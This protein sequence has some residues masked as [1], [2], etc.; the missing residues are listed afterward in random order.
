MA[1]TTT[2]YPAVRLQRTLPAPPERVYRAWLDPELL[3]CWLAPSSWEVT[4]VEVDEVVGGHY[5]I[6]QRSADGEVGGFECELSEL[7]PAERIVLRWGFVGPD[8]THGPRYDSL[9]TITLREAADGATALTLVH[10]RLD[11]LHAALP[12][13]ADNVQT[14]WE[15]VLDKLVKT[16]E[17]AR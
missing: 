8:R 10:E 6:W 7:V 15:L 1:P 12:H 2:D 13:V 3:R 5:R 11:A 14:G 9:L 16:I 17:H 4:D